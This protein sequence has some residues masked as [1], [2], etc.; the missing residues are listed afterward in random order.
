MTNCP[1]E[2]FVKIISVIVWVRVAK[3]KNKADVF[4]KYMSEEEVSI[5][6]SKKKTVVGGKKRPAKG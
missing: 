5:I 1:T 4:Q 2:V 3:E 6:C